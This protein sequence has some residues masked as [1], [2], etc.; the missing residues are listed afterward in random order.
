MAMSGHASGEA[1]VGVTIAM[2]ILAS[3]AVITRLYTRFGIVRNAGTDDVFIVLALVRLRAYFPRD[4]LL[5]H[6][7]AVLHRDDSHYDPASEVR[8]GLA[9]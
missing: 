9:L 3:M 4:T 7:T 6:R 8:H 2:T 5:T 1:V